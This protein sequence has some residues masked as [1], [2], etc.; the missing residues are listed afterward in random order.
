[1]ACSQDLELIDEQPAAHL[2]QA[3]HLE[4]LRRVQQGVSPLGSIGD[5]EEVHPL[6]DVLQD[7]RIDV[8]L[9]DGVDPREGLSESLVVECGAESVGMR[10]QDVSMH[11]NRNFIL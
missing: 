3:G 6:Q 8:S 5:V 4:V 1:L 2:P 11:L 9:G 7:L 10:R